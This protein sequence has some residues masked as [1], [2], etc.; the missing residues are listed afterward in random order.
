MGK[1]TD[2]TVHAV[3]GRLL[4]KYRDICLTHRVDCF[5]TG[6]D[7]PGEGI[8]VRGVAAATQYLDGDWPAPG[9]VWELAC[10]ADCSMGAALVALIAG[11]GPDVPLFPARM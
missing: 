11:A 7:L 5:G 6:A 2:T 1:E 8:T 9:S 4:K 3:D 10:A